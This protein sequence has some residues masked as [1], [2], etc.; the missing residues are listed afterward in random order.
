M[1][2]TLAIVGRPNVGKSTLFNRLTGM[3][4]ALAD[5]TPGLTRDRREGKASLG[6]LHFT[7]IDT[8]GL[9]EEADPDFAPAMRTQTQAA[10]AQAEAVLFVIDGRA[11]LT[12]SD[13]E[14]ARWLRKQDR[15]VLLVVNKCEGTTDSGLDET[16]TLGFGDPVAISAEHNLGL[17][18][19]YDALTALAAKYGWDMEDHS[20]P[21][22][23]KGPE[24][25]PVRIAL[26]GRPNVGKSTLFNRLLG[27]ERTLA[28]PQAGMT[29]DA[30]HVEWRH[31]G[32]SIC[33]VDTAGVRRLHK[34]GNPP[35][36]LAVA[37]SF[38]ALRTAD[39]AI[40]LLDAVEG[41]EKQD[42]ALASQAIEEGKGLVIGV[43]KSD[44]LEDSRAAARY[45]AQAM[46]VALGQ[47]KGVPIILL[48]L[49]HI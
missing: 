25:R 4:A 33:L 24:D 1:L 45:F 27:E 17:D 16:L 49:I 32:K 15:I 30:I 18:A 9:G 6:G 8:P 43:N 48:S 5:A 11:G 28:G 47:A 37:D 7:V 23:G 21:K 34:Q 35:E 10:V 31:A 40:L 36:A 29:R 13:R 2:P 46:D 19:L 38:K 42:L 41:V 22:S 14:C 12:Q 20:S 3:R 39:V 26:L 44:L